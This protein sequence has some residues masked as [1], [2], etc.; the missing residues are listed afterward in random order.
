M[1][2]SR[3]QSN[4]ECADERSTGLA[5]FSGGSPLQARNDSSRGCYRTGLIESNG[6][7]GPWNNRGQM[8]ALNC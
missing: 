7:L 2:Q 8:A 5:N 1:L 3:A 6:I 4:K